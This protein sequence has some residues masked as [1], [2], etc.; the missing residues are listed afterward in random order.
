MSAFMCS[1]SLISQIVNILDTGGLSSGDKVDLLCLVKPFG[2]RRDLF[3]MLVASNV[4]SLNARYPDS[5]DE[6][7]GYAKEAEYQPLSAAL[8]LGQAIK[9]IDCYRYQSCEHTGWINDPMNMFTRNL[10]SELADIMVRRTDEY[11]QAKWGA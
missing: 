10:R 11:E 8:N 1:D 4:A 6:H 9:N 7:E 5:K 2:M 3:K